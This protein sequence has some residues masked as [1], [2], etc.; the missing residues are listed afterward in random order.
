MDQCILYGAGNNGMTVMGYLTM[1]NLEGYVYAFC[2]ADETKIGQ[3]IHNKPIIT[4][5]QAKDLG[6]PIVICVVNEDFCREIIAMLEKDG[7]D[8]YNDILTWLNVKHHMDLTELNRNFC[9]YYH[10]DRMDGYFDE[11]EAEDGVK[12]MKRFWDKDS[13]FYRMFS[14]LELDNVIELACGR[15]R[16]VMKYYEKAN[17]ITLVDILEKNISICKERFKGYDNISYYKNSGFDLKELKNEEY[18]ALFTYDAMVHFE[19]F[20]IYDYL[21][22]TYRVLRQGG[23]ALFHHSNLALEPDQSFKNAHNPGGRSFMDRKLFAYLANK[24]GLEIVE[25]QVIDWTLPNM[26]CIT[27]VS[28]R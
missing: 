5:I 2:D 13:P 21:K 14:C 10:V 26:D 16:H 1:Y 4:Y 28:K 19:L 11:A 6:L 22:E 9:A 25:Q 24:A 27:L 20:D 18:S 15:G 17:H 12:G 23:K 8:Y 3:S 7:V